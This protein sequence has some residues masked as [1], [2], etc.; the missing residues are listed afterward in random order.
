[1]NITTRA[2][3][4]AL[5]EAIDTFVRKELRSALRLVDREVVSVDVSLK[6]INGPKGGADKQ[7][8]ICVHLRN[9]QQVAVD[10]VHQN[11]YA[12]IKTGV[13]RTRRTVR[14]ALQKSRRVDRR[15]L[16]ELLDD[17]PLPTVRRA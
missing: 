9:R 6:D 10:T 14:R 2:N 17:R 11:L 3:D 12:A 15:S 16:R 5:T 7:V 4:F 1:M 8:L 13:R